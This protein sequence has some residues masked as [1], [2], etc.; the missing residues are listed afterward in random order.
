M[1]KYTVEE[2]KKFSDDEII[3]YLEESWG[4]SPDEPITVIGLL[5]RFI[6]DVDKHIYRLQ[7]IESKNGNIIEY[8]IIDLDYNF[9]ILK[10]G[11]FVPPSFY[12]SMRGDISYEDGLTVTC[13]L[14][15]NDKKEREKHNNPCELKVDPRSIVPLS[16][17]EDEYII[18][19]DDQRILIKDTIVQ[20]HLRKN[21]ELIEKEIK[22]IHSER[23]SI[24]NDTRKKKE[25]GQKQIKTLDQQHGLLTENINLLEISINEKEEYRKLIL[26]EIEELKVLLKKEEAVMGEKLEKF[27]SF[28]KDK[29]DN[30]LK[31]EF[32][33]QDEYDDILMLKKK[34]IENEIFID[35][36]EVLNGDFADAIS[37]IQAYLF[38]NDIVYPR[39]I[40]EDFFA[41]IKTNDLIILAGESGSGKTNLI[42]SFA[43]AV[44][45]RSIIIPVKPN[46]T[47]AEDLLGYYNP[48]EK[49]YLSTPFLEALFEAS[50]NPDIPYFICLDEM[51][52]A[53]V[54]YYF[55]DFLSLLEERNEAPEIKLYSEDESSH[56]LSEF[57]NVL[58]LIEQ[59]K[60]KYQKGNIVDFVSIL[61][62]EEVSNELKRVFGF[63]DKDSLIKYHSD[64]RRMISGILNTPSSIILPKNVRIIG[65]I[66]I[67]ETTHYLSPKI[68]DR[69]HIIK[70]DS[71]LLSNWDAIE[72]EVNLNES[73][74]FKLKFKIE[75][76]GVRTPYPAFDMKD[77]FVKVLVEFSRKYF[78]PLGIEFGMRT[79]R[80]GLGYREIFLKMNN[81]EDLVFNNFIIHKILPK[82]TFYANKSDKKDILAKFK[83]KIDDL[84]K[85]KID[86]TQGKIAVE[87]LESLVKNSESNENIVNYWA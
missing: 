63:G 19:S 23:D 13:T 35:F 43:K 81:N 21:K 10:R 82:M 76:F 66:N 24:I 49:K 15:L 55:A 62:D 75:D 84:L 5:S 78:N 59:T 22:E 17:I 60:E 30:L 52:L 6:F 26:D 4:Y 74:N 53:R 44:G 72:Q 68:L 37:H 34:E 36:H 28:I 38:K 14:I 46:W 56:V 42:K 27:R 1:K 70:F 50:K 61:Q 73:S 8:P 85:D 48:L 71:P 47:S 80:Q 32:I 54:E 57:K 39:Y 65:A 41:L 45:G 87:E 12:R 29:A 77:N 3:S 33:E 18:R 69:A 67:D 83:S 51:N 16:E 11:V 9:F 64:L 7:N 20:H 58:H 2:L 86:P 25:D 40:I 79:I 31:L